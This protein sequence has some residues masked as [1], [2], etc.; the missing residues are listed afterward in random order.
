MPLHWGAETR[1]ERDATVAELQ[2]V[3]A[4]LDAV[5]GRVLDGF[6]AATDLQG[7]Y[8]IGTSEQPPAW[9]LGNA[10]TATAERPLHI[11]LHLDASDR[12]AAPTL[13]VQIQGVAA[14]VPQ[15]VHTLGHVLHRETGHRVR[16][17]GTDGKTEVW[18]QDDGYDGRASHGPHPPRMTDVEA[19]DR[20]EPPIR[21]GR[22]PRPA[23]ARPASR[24]TP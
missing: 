4:G 13:A 1:A 7:Q 5:I 11:A 17:Q 22:G 14:R 6:L 15:D 21:A 20:R 18:P 19:S 24:G 3:H 23:G 8:T 2:Q 9:W 16:V 10:H 12:A